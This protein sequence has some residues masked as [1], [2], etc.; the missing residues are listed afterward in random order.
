VFLVEFLL[1][2]SD[3]QGAHFPKEEFDRVRREL[4]ERFG[5]VTA[6][7][8]SP[9]VGLWEDESGATRRDDLVTFEVM[10]ETLD[11]DWWRDYREQLRQ[12]F[13]Q[14]EIVMRASEFELL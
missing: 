13:R 6:F 3:N 7:M 10:A 2:V 8:R 9:A 5:G 4:T 1:P 11:R 14:Q 12:R